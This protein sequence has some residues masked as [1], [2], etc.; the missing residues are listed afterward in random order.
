MKP[1]KEKP[2]FVVRQFP[3]QPDGLAEYYDMV[4]STRKKA[5]KYA[6]GVERHH[7]GK[8]YIQVLTMAQADS[9][10]KIT[11]RSLGCCPTQ[12]DPRGI[13]A[14]WQMLLGKCSGGGISL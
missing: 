10:K 13:L 7:P 2:P 4:F 6:A 8:F 12:W 5:K 1:S 9:G 11:R 14:R 3:R